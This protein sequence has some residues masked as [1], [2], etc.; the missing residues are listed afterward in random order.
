MR[1]TV[2]VMLDLD[3]NSAWVSGLTMA[4]KKD[5][6]FEFIDV[7]NEEMSID[8]TAEFIR[9]WLGDMLEEQEW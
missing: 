6:G 3:T 1:K 7:Q 4:C 8:S 9:N 2:A 5:V